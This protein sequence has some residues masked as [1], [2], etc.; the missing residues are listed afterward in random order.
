[1]VKGVNGRSFISLCNTGPTSTPDADAFAHT[2][3]F[4]VTDSRADNARYADVVIR[5]K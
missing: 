4:A 2:E 3:S 1:M 5:A